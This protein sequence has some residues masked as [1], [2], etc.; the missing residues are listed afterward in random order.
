MKTINDPAFVKELQKQFPVIDNKVYNKQIYYP[1]EGYLFPAKYEFDEKQ[2]DVKAVITKMVQ[3][4]QRV[5][6]G[7]QEEV[8]RAA[9][10]HTKFSRCRP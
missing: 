8:K 7:H 5:M 6:D 3:K 10:N 4:T 9:R 2:P 1:L